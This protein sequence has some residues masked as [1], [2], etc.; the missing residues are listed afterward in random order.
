MAMNEE[1]DLDLLCR[2]LGSVAEQ[3]RGS[4]G[5]IHSALNRLLPPEDPASGGADEQSAAIL[6]QSYYRLLRVINNLSAAT[7]LAEDTPFVRLDL[8][9]VGWLEELCRQARP[10][11][12]EM[13][14][15]LAFHCDRSY[16]KAG[17]HREHMERLVW[18]LLSNAIKFTPA[19]GRIDV[20][21]DFRG[22][23]I[24]LTVADTGCGISEEMMGVVYERYLHPERIDPPPHGL[25]LGL[26]LCRKIAERH[27]GRF[28]LTSREGEGT[29][30]TV[31]LPDERLEDKT[32]EEAMF[33]YTGGFQPAMVELSDA[34]SY[35]VFSRKNLDA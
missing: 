25:G 21:L 10:L 20:T 3:L 8:E 7:V 35:R 4:L 34:L 12:E 23:Q 14:L 17:V 32:L 13:G 31:S 27:G 19:G 1:Q 15:T 2:V 24:L 9:L 22:D 5:N 26:P 18:N 29:T 16:H 30:V 28:L 33:A 11:A 6:N